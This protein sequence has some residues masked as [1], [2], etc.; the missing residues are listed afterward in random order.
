[1]DG[2][3]RV[4]GY[5]HTREVPPTIPTR[6]PIPGYTPHHGRRGW[7]MRF[8][9]PHHRRRGWSMRHRTLLTLG[10]EAGLCATGSLSPK[11]KRLVYVQ[12]AP[13]H[14]MRRGW[15]MR[16]RTLTLRRRGW[17]MRRGCPSPKEERGLCAE[18]ALL[19]KEERSTMRRG[20]PSP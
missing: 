4:V 9:I 11:G 3:P 2:V 17:S 10:R 20:C 12:P 16:N 14:L 5:L 13:S 15:S 1:M 6:V 18:A 8:M 7:A 19:P